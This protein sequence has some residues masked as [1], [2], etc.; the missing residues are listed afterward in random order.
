MILMLMLYDKMCQQLEHL[1]KSMN[2]LIFSKWS[3]KGIKE[4][5]MSKKSNQSTK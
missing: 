3:M 4:S 5:C 2:L 1:S